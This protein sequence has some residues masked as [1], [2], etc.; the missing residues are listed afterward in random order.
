MIAVAGIESSSP[1]WNGN[2]LNN[3][4]TAEA[5]LY[6]VLSRSGGTVKKKTYTNTAGS[7]RP[8]FL[9]FRFGHFIELEINLTCHNAEEILSERGF[10]WTTATPEN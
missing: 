3:A 1:G 10:Y 8:V 6:Y 4:S 5:G 2:G 9:L 7:E